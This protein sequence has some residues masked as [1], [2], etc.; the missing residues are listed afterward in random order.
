VKSRE[1]IDWMRIA[2]ALTDLAIEGLRAKR[3]PG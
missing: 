1:E 2:A 3:G